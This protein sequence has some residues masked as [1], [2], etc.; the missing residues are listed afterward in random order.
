[1]EL[2]IVAIFKNENHALHEWIDHYLREGVDHFFLVD[3]GSNDGYDL[4]KYGETVDIWINPKK[5]AQVELINH[6]LEKAKKYEW[7][8]VVDLDEFMYA[9]K[10]FKT[11]KEYLRSVR[12]E[13]SQIMVPWKMFGSS[14]HIKQPKSIIQGFTHRKKYG[15][16]DPFVFV[17]TIIRSKTLL[18]MNIHTHHT[19]NNKNLDVIK[20]DNELVIPALLISEKLLESSHLH[21]NHYIIQSW[22]WYTTV[23]MKRGSAAKKQNDKHKKSIDYFKIRDTNELLDTELKNKWLKNRTHRVSRNRLKTVRRRRVH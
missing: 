23:K 7:V 10:G 22:D 2:C 20:P 14:G 13:V 5:H 16:I 12:P 19:T 6:Y 17:K 15:D 9:R 18:K 8:M 11:I 1:M 3:N 21:L 4:K